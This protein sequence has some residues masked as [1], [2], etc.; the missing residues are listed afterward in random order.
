M[1]PIGQTQL[2][3]S[4]VSPELTVEAMRD[5]G[6]K[7]TDH[8]LA[9][10]IDN[11]IDA[12]ANLVELIA[13]ET[14]PD[15]SVRYSRARISE[16]AVVDDGTGMDYLTLRRALKYGDGTR[17]DRVGGRIGRFGVG[18]PNA[19]MSQC[20]RVDIW[21]WENGADNALHCYLDLNEIRSGMRE[22]PEP[23][24]DP[25]PRR[26]R[27][28]SRCT[29]EAS[30][31]LVVWSRLDRVR[32]RGGEKT[33]DRTAELCG[34]IYRKFLTDE[35]KPV[36]I[37]LTLAEQAGAELSPKT[38]PSRCLPN[39][40]L[41]L[42]F[43]SSTPSPFHDQAMFR[44]FNERVWTI[45]VDRLEGRVEVRC[46]LARPD[47]INEKMSSVSWPRSYSKAG[48]APWGKHAHK[49]KGVS[50]VRA[51]RELEMSLAWINN[52][53]PE[54]RW[55][56]V[57]VEF[58][59]ILDEI[60]GV[61]NNKQH[62]H[63]FVNGAGF[64]WIDSAYPGETYSVFRERLNETADPRAHLI[65]IWEWIDKQ[66]EQMRRERKKLMKGTGTTRSR[67]PK[68]GEE[69]EDVATNI[70]REQAQQDIVG[71]SD[72]APTTSRNQKIDQIIQS[73]KLRRVEE[74][75]AREWAIETVDNGRRVLLK[76]V[77]LG[78]K[79][80]FF[81]VSSV[82]DVI[83]VWINDEHPVYE[84]LIEAI[85]DFD[86]DESLTDLTD[87]LER[88]A[89]TLKMILI[90]WARHEDKVGSTL[91]DQLHDVRT[92]WGREAR[93]FLSAIEQ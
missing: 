31:T 26:W 83:E 23:T 15:P 73:A 9:E 4:I 61:T 40:P 14:P 74:P 85:T 43:P 91:R 67:H 36:E 39:D 81:D 66:I 1:E 76:S 24:H 51:Q 47:A 50:I 35:S 42:M 33:L 6:Y 63:D 60:F 19:S 13:I 38:E 64:D 49:N 44:Q 28:I 89:F 32:W 21:T 5:S 3:F 90:A 11:A 37:F 62:A 8:A 10:L 7:D 70:I 77:T 25:V 57:E 41:Y 59:P 78:H 22:V 72:R 20:T 16:I 54:E 55:W 79:N 48:E 86:G 69:A 58:D 88:A 12:E 17:M 56:T 71:L 46:T 93:N 68:T 18:L 34:R 52:Y 30:G 65:E 87:R 82:N 27:P 75:L 84:H 2:D 92:D 29:I 80:A 53:E 45:P